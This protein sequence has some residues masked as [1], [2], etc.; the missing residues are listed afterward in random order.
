[1]KRTL[2]AAILL[3]LMAG[4]AF[5]E[6]SE[7]RPDAV[8]TEK[9]QYRFRTREITGETAGEWGSWISNGSAAI[10][11]AAD[12]EVRTVSHSAVTQVTGYSYRRYK[13]RNASNGLTY[14]SYGSGYAQANGYGGSW[15]TKEVSAA[16]RS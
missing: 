15:Q 11:A 12:R 13:Y 1:M 8:Y 16:N 4:T 9:T 3:A 2:L 6:W 5:A 14:Y 7:V 10:A